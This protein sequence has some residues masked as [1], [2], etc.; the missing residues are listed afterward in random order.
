MELIDRKAVIDMI[1]D[2]IDKTG[3]SS[4]ECRTARA[5]GDV[6]EKVQDIPTARPNAIPVEWITDRLNEHKS[7]EALQMALYGKS[8]GYS[9]ALQW[10]LDRW[11]SDNG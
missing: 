1:E 4:S 8:F 7:A 10:L 5:Y 9:E 3:F 2:L 11:E 6:L